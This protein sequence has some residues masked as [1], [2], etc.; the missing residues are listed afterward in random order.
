MKRVILAVLTVAMTSSLFAIEKD[1]VSGWFD[2]E[3]SDKN[4]RFNDK[5]LS[6]YKSGSMVFFRNDTAYKFY[7]KRDLELDSLIVCPELMKLGMESGTFAYDAR[8]KMIYYAKKDGDGNT[9]LYQAREFGD[10]F[11]E[12][13]PMNIKGVMASDRVIR[14]SAL[15]GGRWNHTVPSLKGF[16]NPSLGKNGKRIYFSG[17]FKSGKGDRD[18]WFIEKENEEWWSR[19][20]SVGDSVNTSV[21]EDFA[22]EIG[23]TALFF[24]SNRPG[25]FGDMDIYISRKSKKDKVWGPVENIGEAINSSAAD[26][27]IAFNRVAMYFVSDRKGGKGRAD[28]YRPSRIDPPRQNEL[29]A[30]KT[31]E[32]PKGFH[33]V[34]FFFDFGKTD[35]KPEYEAQLDELYKALLEFPGAE[36]EISGHTDNRGSDDFNK[37]LSQKRAE[38]V[39]A[40]L[41]QR[42]YDKRLLKA[43]GKGKNEPILPNAVEEYEHEQNRRVDIKIINND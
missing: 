20:Q 36:F 29:T 22:L 35:M 4:T 16:H 18:L 39:K 10:K 12:A 38:Y 11:K 9:T 17:N 41:V 15:A 32:E 31:I 43:I 25:G 8:T 26:Y 5:A 28:I 30:E 1:Y 27:N 40:L 37:K 6:P 3:P 21:C 34:L 24:A 14:G 23:D 42:G 33:W 19:P 13:K 7:P 2:F